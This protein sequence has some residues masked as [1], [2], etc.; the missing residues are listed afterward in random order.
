MPTWNPE[1]SPDNRVIWPPQGLPLA[2]IIN[3]VIFVVLSTAAIGVRV[4]VRAKDKVFGWDDGLMVV[5]GVSSA[6]CARSFAVG[7]R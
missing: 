4:F 6:L 7:S 3:V 2:V 1:V 5:G